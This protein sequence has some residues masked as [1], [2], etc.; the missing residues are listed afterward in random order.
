MKCDDLEAEQWLDYSGEPNP[1]YPQKEVDS[2][3][4][5]LKREHHRER[6]E[7]IDWVNKL[8][9]EN[10]ELKRRDTEHMVHIAK[11]NADLRKTQ[12]ALW[13]ARHKR[14]V[15]TLDYFTIKCKW[16]NDV[17]K[18]E[19]P[20]CDVKMVHK[21]ATIERKCRAKAKEFE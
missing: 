19:P 4:D 15:M 21:W 2:A 12:R 3:I 9:K 5:E 18:V 20:P 6:D 8:Q 11:M 17:M 7:Y 1:C 10:A 13:L 14:A 16:F